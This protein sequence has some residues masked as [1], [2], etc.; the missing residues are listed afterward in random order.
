M[1]GMGKRSGFR[2]T[3]GTSLFSLL[4]VGEPALVRA[5]AAGSQ[6]VSVP[7]PTDDGYTP[8]GQPRRQREKDRET[9][10]SYSLSEFTSK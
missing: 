10:K 1:G 2:G 3:A 9:E 4:P 7:L 5:A 8:T 6:A